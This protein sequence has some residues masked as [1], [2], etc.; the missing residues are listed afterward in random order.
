[1][2]FTIRDMLWF[3]VVVMILAAWFV[4]HG[5]ARW[6]S[7]VLEAKLSLAEKKL[8]DLG[9]RINAFRDG[10]EISVEPIYRPV[11]K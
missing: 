1:M 10:R 5:T 11:S 9:W 8:G 3:I 2:R 6:N 7:R 4:D